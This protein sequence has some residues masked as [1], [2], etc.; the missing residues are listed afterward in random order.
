MRKKNG[1]QFASEPKKNIWAWTVLLPVHPALSASHRLKA[2][3]QE[4]VS[5][6]FFFFG[7]LD[8]RKSRNSD[9]V[10]DITTYPNV[11]DLQKPK[12]LLIQTG[13]QMD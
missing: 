13:N 10:H 9:V 6:A 1:H 4:Q 5:F 11:S 2:M 3:R 12:N 7:S 8:F